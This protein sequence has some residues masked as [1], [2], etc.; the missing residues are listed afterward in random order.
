MKSRHGDSTAS[1]APVEPVLR[2]PVT[3]RVN[4]EPPI[5]NG[6]TASEGIRIAVA[7]LIVYGFIGSLIYAVTGYWQAS[8][9]FMIFATGASL[10][11]ASIYLARIKRGRPEGYYV[12]AIHLWIADL[13]LKQ[14]QFLR[15]RSYWS[16]GRTMPGFT[17][18]LVVRETYDTCDEKPR[19]R[20]AADLPFDWANS[21]AFGQKTP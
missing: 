20:I 12:Q 9:V 11:Y 19:K 7:C 8:V 18:A 2:A 14:V 3:D 5:L 21:R 13:G 15:H 10:W 17:S 1:A 16:L 4:S 6:M